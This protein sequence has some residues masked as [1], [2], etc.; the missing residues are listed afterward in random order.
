MTGRLL[1][2]DARLIAVDE[3]ARV[4]EGG[5]MLCEDGIIVGLG[6]GEPPDADAS[7]ER[8]DAAGAFVGPGF[9]SSHSHLFTSVARGLGT[10]ETL[11][12][13]C[14]AMYAVSTGASP[15]DVYWASVHGALDSIA[16]GVTTAF[17]FL[18]PCTAWMSMRGAAATSPR[19]RPRDY[20]LRQIDAHEDAGIRG[21]LAI[22]IEGGGDDARNDLGDAV[23]YARSADRRFVL[24]AAVYGAAQWAADERLAAAEA[25]A[26]RELGLVNQAHLLETTEQLHAQH[27]KFWW[28]DRAGALGPDMIFGHF[29]HPTPEI[30]DAVARSRSAVSWQPVANGR[31]ASGVA[32]VGALRAAGVPLGLG[33]DDQACSDVS[34]PWQ[35]M[36]FG[37]YSSRGSTNRTD[38]SVADVLRMQTLG[39]AEIIHVDD[40]VGSLAVGKYA[41]FVVVDPRRP[42]VGPLHDPLV[43]YV[44]AMSLRNLRAVYVGGVLANVGGESTSPLARI[45]SDEVHRRFAPAVPEAAL[46]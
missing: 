30:V 24:D 19:I 14:D 6:A 32:D 39:A 2:A 40:R 15:D 11:Y 41:D 3:S 4:I 7:T 36:R 18:D 8:L 13:W 38:L 34:D 25:A 45:A 44:L 17:D 29:V 35:N 37:L 23:A 12:G 26:M 10:G 9:V 27:E 28:Y 33:L 22:K 46:A 43:S 1:V 20:V 21:V 31:L 42:D 16:S 5:W